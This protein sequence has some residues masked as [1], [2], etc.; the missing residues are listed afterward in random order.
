MKKI[1]K[2][3]IGFY[4]YKCKWYSFA[5]GTFIIASV[6]TGKV[7]ETFFIL[8]GYR[9][10]RYVFPSTLHLDIVKECIITNTI[11]ITFMILSTFNIHVSIYFSLIYTFIVC[12]ILYVINYIIQITNPKKIKH[13]RDKIIDILNGQV[14]LENILEFCK[15]HGIKEEVG[16]TVDKFLTMTIDK[17]CEQEYLTETAIKKRIKHFIENASK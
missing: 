10:F 15:S 3:L 14:S 1:N 5:F 6:L 12:L 9:F 7:F 11:L 16:K 2:N 17:V 13:N 4:I 8:I